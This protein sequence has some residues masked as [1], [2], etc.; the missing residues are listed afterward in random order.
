MARAVEAL[1]EEVRSLIETSEFWRDARDGLAI[2]VQPRESR[3]L[4]VDVGL[5][6]QLVVGGRFSIRPLALA[7]HGDERFFALAFDRDGSRL[8]EGDRNAIRELDIVGGPGS[9][10]ESTKFDEREESLQFTTHASP[11]STAGVGPAI[12]MFVS[13]N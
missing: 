12:G 6:E 10:A 4:E 1:L 13:R 9:F 2:F 5:P 11:E 7:Y 8:F 3:V